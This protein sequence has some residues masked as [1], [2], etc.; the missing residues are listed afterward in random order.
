MYQGYLPFFLQ[1]YIS[2]DLEDKNPADNEADTPLDIAA[3]KGHLENVNYIVNHLKDKNPAMN[4]GQ[5]LLH[6]AAQEGHLEIVKY[7][8]DD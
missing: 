6:I 3:Q 7:I 2:Q 5:T 1:L 8:V 4:D